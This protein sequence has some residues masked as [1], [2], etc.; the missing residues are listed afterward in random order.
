MRSFD[1]VVAALLMIEVPEKMKRK[2]AWHAV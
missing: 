2:L 1:P